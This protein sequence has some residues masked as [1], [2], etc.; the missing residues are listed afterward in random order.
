MKKDELMKQ[1]YGKTLALT[2][3]L[4]QAG[5]GYV[6]ADSNPTVTDVTSTYIENAGFETDNATTASI[7]IEKTLHAATIS[8]WT[9]PTSNT[10]YFSSGIFSY[11][12]SY[13]LGG[14]SAPAA[15]PNASDET[16]NNALGMVAG[17]SST[18]A[19]TQKAKTNLTAGTYVFTAYVYN[20]AGTK[21]C[22]NRFGFVTDGGTAYY[23]STTSFTENAWT[24]ETVAFTITTETSGYFS[25]GVVDG[26]Q[27]STSSPRLFISGVKLEKY[28]YTDESLSVGDVV[29]NGLNLYTIKGSNLFTNGSFS[30]V[31]SGWVT[32]AANT[33]AASTADN[34]WTAT[35][36][37]DGGA[38]ITLAGDGVSG[39]NIKQN[40][41]VTSGNTYYYVVYTKDSGTTAGT[42]S[43]F[44][45]IAP[46]NAST[47]ITSGTNITETNAA[48][49]TNGKWVKTAA[50]FTATSSS[51]TQL[52]SWSG[53]T[54]A[55]GFQLYEL[56]SKGTISSGTDVTNY[57]ITNPGFEQGNTNGWSY[58]GV[59]KG[60]AMSTTDADYVTEGSEGSY[61]FSAWHSG[62]GNQEKLY[63]SITLPAGIYVL[64][65]KVAYDHTA[66]T[67]TSFAQI[68]AG[69]NIQYVD[70]HE[71]VFVQSAVKF[72][73]E[74]SSTIEIGVER[75]KGWFKA[76]DFHLYYFSSENSTDADTK[77][78]ELANIK[79]VGLA[80]GAGKYA[81]RIFP[82]KPTSLPSGVTAYSC[83]AVNNST[84]QLTEVSDPAADTPYLLYSE[85]TVE[86]TTLKDAAAAP[87]KT[88]Y[89][90]GLLTGVMSG[91][92]IDAGTYALQTQDGV[93]AFY[94]VGTNGV[95]LP[96]Y[97][98]Y[99]K[100]STEDTSVRALSLGDNSATAI[101]AV[102]ALD[103]L[104]SGEAAIYDLSGRRLSK[105][106]KG[107]NI[108][109]GKKVIVK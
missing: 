99:L 3:L 4:L 50:F 31:L 83:S 17:W 2:A 84:L 27:T 68:F 94:I 87:A 39:N 73:L 45:L 81:S 16:D 13:T 72:T 97:R 43:N 23:G 107:V 21:T 61:L 34:A 103:A 32:D 7:A 8:N 98:A 1:L 74:E 56:E 85:T 41:P 109:N 96:A 55:D 40:I 36:G 65:A 76:D 102:E 49:G 28:E 59:D 86:S 51:V 44:R 47:S 70:A 80:I 89:T 37:P 14:N 38:Y 30:N 71:N 11:G 18:A 5:A 10:Q 77:L 22:T 12:S 25:V 75:N 95:T 26:G 78:A 60:G 24:T 54:M 53:G 35:G 42:N 63:Q 6:L 93:Q 90:E 104:T 67:S 62:T 19:Y 48:S 100:L 9:A 57:F 106:Q 101:E 105:L 91:T 20:A 58:W 82:F 64:S 66:N 92:K 108:V 52:T 79:E 29:A 33:T 46:T 15:G 88:A 69:D